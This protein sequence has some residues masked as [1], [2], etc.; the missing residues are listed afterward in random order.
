MTEKEPLKF[1][2]SYSRKV[3]ARPYE[4]MEIGYWQEFPIEADR[5]EAFKA[6][7]KRVEG[8]IYERLYRLANQEKGGT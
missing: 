1:G 3:R 4:S 7:V 8:W 5:E 6:V 2:I